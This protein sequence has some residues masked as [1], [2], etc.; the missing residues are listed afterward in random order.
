MASEDIVKQMAED[1]Q[2][3]AKLKRDADNL[4]QD[5]IAIQ[6]VAYT[7]LVKRCGDPVR[8][9]RMAAIYC[10]DAGLI[11]FEP[12]DN[13]YAQ[14]RMKELA[15]QIREPEVRAAWKRVHDAARELAKLVCP[16]EF[17]HAE[18]IKEKFGELGYEGE[19]SS[20]PPKR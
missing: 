16:N 19:K 13:D 5:I 17:A 18:A 1:A 10:I 6:L 14:P 3:T 4:T 8:A 11:T 15:D 2:R 7:R 12:C 9:M 20:E